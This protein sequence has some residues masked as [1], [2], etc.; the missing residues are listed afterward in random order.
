MI[1]NNTN[2][3]SKLGAI[4]AAAGSAVG[5]G[6]VW[7]FPTEAGAN[8]GAAFILIYVLFML[9]LGVPVMISELAIGRHGQKNVSHS[10]FVMSGNNKLW[11]YMGLLPVV[12]GFLVLSYY[13][14]V[15]GWTLE[16]A[17][18]AGVNGLSDKTSAQYAADFDAFTSDP[19]RPILWLGVILAVTC[20]IVAMGVQRGIE[21]GAKIMM[22]VLFVCI[23]ILVMCSFTLPGAEKGLKFFFHPDFSKMTSSTALSAMGQAFFSLSVGICCLCTYGCYF[24][25]DVNLIK[26]SLSVAGIDTLVALM[27]GLIVFPAVYSISGLEPDSG[28]SLVFIT[29][30]NVFQQVF[31][32]APALS[33]VFS[34][35]FYLLL[36]MAALTSSV[37]MLEMSAAIFIRKFKLGRPFSCIMVTFICFLFGS[38]CA[39]SFGVWSDVKVFGLTTFELFD[40]LVAKLLMPIGALLICV[41]A[42]WVVDVNVLRDELTNGGAVRQPLWRAY[43]LLIRYVAPICILLI[44]IN[45]LGLF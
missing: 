7:R 22:P 3:G 15:A 42:G 20:T 5:L 21:L 36:V 10:F 8:G 24:R 35:L 18:E 17:I 40:F 6:N 12:A 19:L 33:Y 25:K 9:I 1:D 38:A 43:R 29:L 44:F 28:P 2:F 27:S 45:E 14:V 31:A 32:G 37:S 34:L 13:A 4:L 30:P 23:A 41:F 26:D 11:G 16:Y 39:L